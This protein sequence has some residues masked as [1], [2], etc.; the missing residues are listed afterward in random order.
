MNVVCFLED[1]TY[2]MVHR[3]IRIGSR[4]EQ[5]GDQNMWS[6]GGLLPA[7]MAPLIFD[8]FCLIAATVA[9][10]QPESLVVLSELDR[11]THA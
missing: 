4:P 10:K 1:F 9:V 2:N 5:C 7:T 3:G 11:Q 6:T 8:A